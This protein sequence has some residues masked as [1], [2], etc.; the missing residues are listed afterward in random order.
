MFKRLLKTVWP[1]V[2]QRPKV[3][4]FGRSGRLTGC[5]YV[6]S[7]G[8][9][10]LEAGSYDPLGRFMTSYHHYGDVHEFNTCGHPE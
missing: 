8:C 7:Y 4:I 9:L 3:V 6:D 2:D 10:F 1:A 5:W